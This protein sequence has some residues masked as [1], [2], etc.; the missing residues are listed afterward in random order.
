MGTPDFAVPSLEKLLDAGFE[1]TAVVTA[2]DKPAG[3]GLH[4][5]QSAVKKFAL[6]KGLKVLQ[7]EKLKDPDFAQE[8]K[9]LKADIQ[10]VVAF[11]MLVPEC[12]EICGIETVRRPFAL[13]GCWSLSVGRDHKVHLVPALVSP[14]EHFA[15]LRTSHNFI[16]HEM[17][18]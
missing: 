12:N 10:I 16:Q 6:S 5:N 8:L 13:D 15:G 18:P 7:P 2:P 3:R 9:N 4:L 11:R 17:L 14:I 1:I